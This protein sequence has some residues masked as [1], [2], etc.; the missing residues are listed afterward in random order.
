MN[1]LS[2]MTHQGVM[3]DQIA[4]LAA[5]FSEQK[6]QVNLEG[7]SK[8]QQ[9]QVIASSQKK[10]SLFCELSSRSCIHEVPFIYTESSF[11]ISALYS[12]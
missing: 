2:V 12:T 9:L 3:V 10:I 11:G 1:Y 5:Y 8:K 4:H 6:L 7:F